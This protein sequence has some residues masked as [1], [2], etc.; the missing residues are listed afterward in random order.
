MAI[1][2]ANPAKLPQMLKKLIEM[3][4]IKKVGMNIEN[5][6]WKLEMD[7]NVDAKQAIQNSTVELKSLAN[8]KLRSA[9]NWSLEGLTK[10]V[11]HLRISKDPKIRTCDWR[12][13]PLP[14]EQQRYAA[15]DA[16]ISL[17]LYRKLTCS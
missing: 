8:K 14:E 1:D 16:I 7:Y 13:Y 12:Q 15:T 11:L 3:K 10:N 4:N 17:M 5:D 9:Q 2:S 6:L